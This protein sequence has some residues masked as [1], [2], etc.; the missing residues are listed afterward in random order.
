MK[1]SQNKLALVFLVVF[2]FFMNAC[3]HTAPYSERAY[4]QAVS[5]KVESLQLIEHASEPYNSHLQ[6]ITQ[7]KTNLQIAYE[8]AANRPDNEFSTKQ[9]AVMIDTSR[10]LMGGFFVFWQ[11]KQT[12]SN[13]FIDN[14]KRQIGKAFDEIILLEQGK[15]RRKE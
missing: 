2:A 8:Y 9:W 15:I 12:L 10:N 14:Y 5:L 6:E 7:L 3:V 13:A 11:K 1:S 4:Y